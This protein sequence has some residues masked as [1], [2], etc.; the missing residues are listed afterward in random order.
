MGISIHACVLPPFRRGLR[1]SGVRDISVFMCP[2]G[3]GEKPSN[4]LRGTR[5]RRRC[6]SVP[7]TKIAR[8]MYRVCTDGIAAQGSNSFGA[9]LDG[10]GSD[11]CL[12]NF[13]RVLFLGR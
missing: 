6:M 3:H 1:Y 7:L 11:F 13:F 2:M 9:T 10:R 5:A 8:C 4:G 12:N